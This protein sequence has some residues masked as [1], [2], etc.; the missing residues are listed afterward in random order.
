MGARSAWG[1]GVRL[2]ADCALC[3]SGLMAIMLVTGVMN[4]GAMTLVTVAITAERLF[5]EPEQA[6]RGVGFVIIAVG[7]FIIGRAIV[8]I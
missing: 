5:P 3:C 7:F 1:H 8:R 4:L 6:A 2:G